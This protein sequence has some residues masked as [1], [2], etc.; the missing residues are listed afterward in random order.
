MGKSSIK[1]IKSGLLE[2]T[3][4]LGRM[5]LAPGVAL[6]KA[7]VQNRFL[8]AEIDEIAVVSDLIRANAK[9]WVEDLSEM[10]GVV[11]KFGQMLTTIDS[12]SMPEELRLTL[13]VLVDEFRALADKSMYL[14]GRQVEKLLR[15][16]LD[17]GLLAE[18]QIETTPIAAASIGQ[19]HRAWIKKSGEAICLKIQYPGIKKALKSDVKTLKALVHNIV[20]L[21]GMNHKE[22]IDRMLDEFLAIVGQEMDYLVEA[23]KQKSYYEYFK[24]D[25]HVIV[26]K[27]YD[28]YTTPTV[29]AQEFIAGIPFDDSRVKALSKSRKQRLGDILLD[30]MVRQLFVLGRFQ[31]DAHIGNYFAQLD[32]KSGKDKLVLLD[33][34]ATI[35]V[36]AGIRRELLRSIDI[37]N[38][39]KASAEAM[40]TP[41]GLHEILD[42]PEA[43]A[44]ILNTVERVH[45]QVHKDG[46]W[47]FTPG[48][49]ADLVDEVF[50][51]SKK[52]LAG[53]TL[54]LNNIPQDLPLIGRG[55]NGIKQLWTLVCYQLTLKEVMKAL[56]T[57]RSA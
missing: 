41:L 42:T 47:H 44:M 53:G 13:Q 57:G 24:D 26:P 15:R 22:P 19:V 18:L 50:Q 39:P 51:Q 29:L 37:A 5:S 3:F 11:M 49:E 34:G 2:R 6:L 32:N 8:G 33:F 27:V 52:M 30:S 40:L 23:E 36:P 16:R 20:R 56:D 43:G 7:R 9:V 12:A 10:K 55:F 14:D 35:K 45:R 21:I 46:Q 1:K 4:T 17:P 25:P 38:D 31:S 54:R 28:R 48:S